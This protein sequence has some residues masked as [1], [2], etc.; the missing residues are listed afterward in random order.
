M[1]GR[2]ESWSTQ[3]LTEFLALVSSF[4]N[5]AS[6][7][8]GAAQRAADVLGADVVAIIRGG[9]V[10]AATGYPDDVVPVDELKR[11][12]AAPE[13]GRLAV[14]GACRVA[15]V[16]LEAD[17]PGQLLVARAG[18]EEITRE[19]QDLLRGMARVLVMTLR[20]LHRQQL[21][22]RLSTIQRMIVRRA[23]PRDV[24]HAVVTGAAELIGDDVVTLHLLDPLD[25]RAA[26]LMASVGLDPVLR[27]GSERTPADAGLGGRAIEADRLVVSDERAAMAAPV[28]EE[29]RV[30]GSIVVASRRPE[31][32]YG[33][34]DQE[35]LLAFAEHASL[36]LTDARMVRT[37]LHQAFH[38]PL[39]DLP[40]RALFVDRLELGLSRVKR[41]KSKLAVLFLDVDRFKIVNDSLGHAA[42]DE[43]LREVAA[44]LV[45]SIRP[46]DTAARFGGDEFAI[47]LEDVEDQAAAEHVALRILGA[48]KAPLQV[49]GRDVFISASI[50]IAMDAESAG[51]MIR[52]ADLAMYR[53]KSE[54]KGRHAVFEPAMHVAIVERADLEADLQR[55]L[56]RAELVLHYQP[57]VALGNRSIVG[58][59]ALVRWRHPSR[60]IVSPEAFIPL[61]EETQLMAELGRWILTEA[62][63]EVAGWRLLRPLRLSVNLSAVQLHAADT[64]AGDVAAALAD[65]GLPPEALV[66]EITETALMRDVT[67]TISCLRALKQLGVLLAVDDFGTGYSSLDYLRRFPIDTL[68]ID[69]AFVDDLGAGDATL[70]QAIIDLGESFDLQVV[71]EGV[72]HEFQRQRL[73]ELGCS[74]GQGYHFSRPMPACEM[75]ALLEA[76]PPAVPLSQ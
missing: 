67:E 56:E 62:C 66:L 34:D 36:A 47:L 2:V 6:A 46:G 12:A 20:M 8:R 30:V 65:S 39:T 24:L 17:E 25:H 27:A 35:V 59:E 29:G 49:A 64:L 11:L 74:Y 3:Q 50:G 60:G 4:G 7:V 58:V 19:E 32:H 45:A 5:A 28:R 53:A 37:A 42:G 73:L 10:S 18:D 61:A 55:V 76:S 38:D 43:L 52:D 71:A 68:K 54:G 72:E 51:D 40:N 69:K 33:A 9:V 41:S 1:N 13:T 23:E 15:V 14:L 22:E 48:L 31:R 75:R 70:A 44:R 63:R 16:T 21:L 26:V 57:I